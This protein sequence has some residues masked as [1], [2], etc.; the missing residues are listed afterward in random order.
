M[1]GL[2]AV[3][4]VIV[5]AGL[6]VT[7]ATLIDTMPA[8]ATGLSAP[9]PSDSP[10]RTPA[11]SRIG[12]GWLPVPPGATARTVPLTTA[13]LLSSGMS[14]DVRI[15][16][17]TSWPAICT[18]TTPYSCAASALPTLVRPSAACVRPSASFLRP[19]VIA[20]TPPRIVLTPDCA[21][22]ALPAAALASAMPLAASCAAFL[23]VLRALSAR[24]PTFLM[25]VFCA[26]STLVGFAPAV[27]AATRAIEDAATAAVIS[28]RRTAWDIDFSSCGTVGRRQDRAPGGTYVARLTKRKC[29]GGRAQ[30]A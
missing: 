9:V 10:E 23:A 5:T 28:C 1:A 25:A 11:S 2:L 20:G 6:P 29:I 30:P 16:P 27:G 8:D 7:L 3:P 26:R 12:R 19:S 4:P 15:A 17:G 13:A 18:L 21:P 22:S 14:A 24:L